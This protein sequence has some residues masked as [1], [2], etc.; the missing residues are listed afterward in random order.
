[1]QQCQLGQR[2]L[3]TSQEGWTGLSL[4]WL[5]MNIRSSWYVVCLWVMDIWSYKLTA[6]HN[7]LGWRSWQRVSL[8]IWRSTVRTCHRASFLHGVHL[9]PLL[10]HPFRSRAL[11]KTLYC[12][13]A[14][15]W[16]RNY[17]THILKVFIKFMCKCTVDRPNQLLWNLQS[18]FRTSTTKTKFQ[19]RTSIPSFQQRLTNETHI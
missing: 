13:S 19:H 9:R 3:T 11:Q 14:L 18:T 5:C 16:D 6:K 17:V 15:R 1:M 12:S 7:Q 2:K 10:I 4:A 8:I